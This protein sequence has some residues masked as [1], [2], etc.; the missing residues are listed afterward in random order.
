MAQPKLRLRGPTYNALDDSGLERLKREAAL[1]PELFHGLVFKTEDTIG[2]LDYL[3]PVTKATIVRFRPEDLAAGIAGRGEPGD[4][5]VCG[6]S[7]GAS[8]GG[9]CAAS[10]AASCGGSCGGSCDNSC[11]G[12]CG[13]SCGASC[14]NSCAGSCATSCVA[15]G[16]IPF[17]ADIVTLPAEQLKAN[18]GEQLKSQAVQITFSRF[19]R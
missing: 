18:I 1:D 15:S 5:D 11:A 19:Q 17:N 12:T 7:C 10:C 14:S 9:T 6:A 8:C 4:A 16:D 3:S 2:Q 13:G